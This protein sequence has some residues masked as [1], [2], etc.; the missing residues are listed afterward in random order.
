MGFQDHERQSWVLFQDGG[1]GSE[2]KI[3]RQPKIPTPKAISFGWVHPV[4]NPHHGHVL[5][6]LA[7]RSV[8]CSCGAGWHFELSVK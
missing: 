4:T 2:W 3:G 8:G 7:Q 6:A 1:M 5:R